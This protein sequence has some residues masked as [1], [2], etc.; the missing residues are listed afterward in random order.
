[1]PLNG[2]TTELKNG[3]A[4]SGSGRW[5]EQQ[6]SPGDLPMHDQHSSQPK[7]GTCEL[8]ITEVELRTKFF[9]KHLIVYEMY[10]CKVYINQSNII[11]FIVKDCTCL[12]VVIALHIL[13]IIHKVNS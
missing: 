9:I 1:M 3:A 13:F 8:H 7:Q 5:K 11:T 4:A 6:G 2:C 10:M 12:I